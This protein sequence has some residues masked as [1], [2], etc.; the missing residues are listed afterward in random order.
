VRASTPEH[1]DVEAIL[2]A[3]GVLVGSKWTPGFRKAAAAEGLTPEKYMS[4]LL[5]ELD[6]RDF[7]DK[8]LA[9]P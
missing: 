2:T 6:A 3:D 9:K 5:R 4:K 7:S 1:H 8:L